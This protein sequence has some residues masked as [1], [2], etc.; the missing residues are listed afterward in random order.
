MPG[1]SQSVRAD[2]VPLAVDMDGT[3]LRTDLIWEYLLRFLRQRPL[4]ALALAGWW[5][6]GRAFLKQQL[7]ARVQ[8]DPTT[9]P[10]SEEFLDWLREQKR[11]G[12][13][14]VLATASDVRMAE[15][16]A[17]HV[18]LFDELLASDGRTNLRDRAKR[19]ALARRFGERG[20]DYAGNSPV[21]LD[22][23]AGARRAIV[24]NA[25]SRL[26]ARAAQ[27]A[28]LGPVFERSGSRAGALLR[29]LRPHQ[30][31]K[32]LIVFVPLV[33]AHQLT[34]WPLL[35]ASGAF[36]ALCLCAAGG[37]VLN[38]LLDLD[39]DRRHPLKRR[40]PFAAG[41]L[42]LALGPG[43]AAALLVAGLVL[44]WMLAPAFAGLLLGYVIVATAYSLWWKR[45]A[46]LD[47][48]VL[49]GLYTLRLAAGHV[50]TGIAW[51][52]WLLVFAMFIFLS[53]AL[54][55]RF[56]ELQ[57]L[58]RQNQARAEGRGYAVGDIELVTTLGLMCGALAVLVM[59]LYVNSEQV[60]R[61]YRHPTLLLAGCPLLLFWI[62]RLW[63]LAHR[64]R[65]AADPVLFVLKDPISY[66]IGALMLL[67][68]WLAS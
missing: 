60:T 27:C 8:V 34:F 9:L 2:P 40:R 68:M 15:P 17:R 31:L 30:W 4:A 65:M 42:P 16:V 11:A 61:L 7:A 25:N 56:P 49:A 58:R 21:D 13:R 54:L 28:E 22:V 19:D 20:F 24:V 14:L 18:G 47:V 44:G 41:D 57:E 48:F 33:T 45:L 1:A 46:L 6:R 64:G 51:S 32:N 67:I 52:A 3:L 10:Y 55:K 63:L 39:A 12:R 59:A 29:L 50:V 37:Y 35:A 5:L 38:D 66:A 36:V 23:W 53:L 26:A 43:L 62:S